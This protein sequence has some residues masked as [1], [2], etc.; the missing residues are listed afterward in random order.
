MISIGSCRAHVWHGALRTGPMETDW[1]INK[2]L[3]AMWKIFDESPARRDIHIR[4]TGCDIFPLHF[5]R[6][7]GLRMN[8]LLHKEFTYG[9]ILSRLRSADFHW[10]KQCPHNNKS[11]DTLVKY[12]TDKLMISKIHFL[13]ILHKS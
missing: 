10:Q 13:N 3:H 2:V 12:H 8:P 1:E 4:E 9:R 5:S 11:F 7:D 6:P